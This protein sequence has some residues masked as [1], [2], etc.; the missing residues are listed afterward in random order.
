MRNNNRSDAMSTRRFGTTDLAIVLALWSAMAVLVGGVMSELA[1]DS[2][3]PMAKAQSEAYAQQL[4][5]ASSVKSDESPVRGP[6]SVAASLPADLALRSGKLGR[7]PWG[8]P[9]SYRIVHSAVIVWSAGRNQEPDS[10]KALERL[11][12]GQPV[13]EFRFMGDDVG[14]VQVSH[15]SNSYQ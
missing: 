6:A 3:T 4:A 14:F 1:S 13:N 2:E 7:D 10:E 9:Y 11:E 5:S 15:N 8:K 12:S